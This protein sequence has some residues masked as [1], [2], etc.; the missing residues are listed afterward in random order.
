LQ[1]ALPLGVQGSHCLPQKAVEEDSLLHLACVMPYL[2]LA[3]EAIFPEK[4]ESL[5]VA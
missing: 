5:F 2:L 3:K 1:A 4:K